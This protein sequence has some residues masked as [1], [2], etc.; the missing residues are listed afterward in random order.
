MKFA[1][2][3]ILAAALLLAAGTQTAFASSDNK[4]GDTIHNEAEVTFTVNGVVQT[5]QPLGTADFTVDRLVNVVVAAT[6]AGP[7]SPGATQGAVLFTVTNDTNSPMDFVLVAANGAGT[8]EFDVGPFTYYIDDGDGVFEPGAGDGAAVTFLDEVASDAVVPVWV[9]SA[10]PNGLANGDTALVTLKAT[11]HDAGA[12]GQGA[13]TTETAGANTAGIDNVFGDAAGEVDDANE[14]DHSAVSNYVITTATISVTKSSAV[15]SD[16]FNL[17]TNPKA[18]PGA[19]MVYC[20]AVANGSATVAATDVTISDNIP[21][22]T[23]Y[24]A[25]TIRVVPNAITCDADAIT[26]GASMTDA[27]DVEADVGTNPAGT[28]G[29][30]GGGAGPITTVTDLPIS[31]TT[32]TVFQVT[33]D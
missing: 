7:T 11:A 1:T 23:T 27:V 16:P 12:V 5:T 21:A 29:D 24:V 20:I 9:V 8:D 28:T 31:A 4:A 22:G 18:I 26:E 32:T 3:K 6:G 30:A 10:I 17:T 19:T 13:L 25:G 15:V 2:T 33:I 14:G